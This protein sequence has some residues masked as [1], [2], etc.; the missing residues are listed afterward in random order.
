MAAQG[1]AAHFSLSGTK[2]IA[3]PGRCTSRTCPTE[4]STMEQID[5]S[6]IEIMGKTFGIFLFRVERPLHHF[7]HPSCANFHFSP[8]SFQALRSAEIERRLPSHQ[9]V[10]DIF[11]VAF[12]RARVNTSVLRFETPNYGKMRRLWGLGAAEAGLEEA[13][14]VRSCNSADAVQQA[15]LSSAATDRASQDPASLPASQPASRLPLSSQG[16]PAFF[17]CGQLACHSG[18]GTKQGSKPK[19]MRASDQ[20]AR[21]PLSSPFATRPT[22]NHVGIYSVDH[23]I[24]INFLSANPRG[25]HSVHCFL[26]EIQFEIN[27]S[28]WSRS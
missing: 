7:L 3:S 12:V 25:E 2:L 17:G 1:H 19:G 9:K 24:P 14:P 15:V 20:A 21:K 23:K 10:F 5:I 18:A 8:T 16:R 28:I 11:L 6:D 26:V 22:Y 13:M 27:C 4:W